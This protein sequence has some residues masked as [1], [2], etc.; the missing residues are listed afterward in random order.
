[1]DIEE[2][3]SE[4][5]NKRDSFGESVVEDSAALMDYTSKFELWGSQLNNGYNRELGSIDFS[6]S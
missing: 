1:M 2:K 3:A 5:D 4:K 6:D